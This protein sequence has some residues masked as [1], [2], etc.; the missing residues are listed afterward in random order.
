MC[1]QH[2][3]DNFTFYNTFIYNKNGPFSYS[4]TAKRNTPSPPTHPPRCKTPWSLVQCHEMVFRTDLFPAS[5]TSLTQ[6]L[7]GLWYAIGH[8]RD[9]HFIIYPWH[10]Q[11]SI[12]CI[13]DTEMWFLL[14]Y[15]RK[16]KL[17]CQAE[18][19]FVL[20]ISLIHQDYIQNLS[21]FFYAIQL[22]CLSSE[23]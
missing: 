1:F 16:A 11:I 9:I 3:S 17:S 5:S 14:S 15:C 21:L 10:L 23:T 20:N 13:L 8:M 4:L 19:R 2:I 12:T 18:N 7:Q 6:C 22:T